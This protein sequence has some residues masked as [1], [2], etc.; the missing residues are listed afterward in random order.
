AGA[1]ALADHETVLPERLQLL[2]VEPEIRSPGLRR[3]RGISL[4]LI[5]E[6]GL[7]RIEA[8]LVEIPGLAG[9]HPGELLGGHL[10][11]L[12][13]RVVEGGSVAESLVVGIG[14]RLRLVRKRLARRAQ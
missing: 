7:R 5:P 14:P 3:L 1:Q 9:K 10:A 8:D 4:E 13:Q 11:D 12:L 6:F 2:L